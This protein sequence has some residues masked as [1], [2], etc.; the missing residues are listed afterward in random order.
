MCANR[1][2]GFEVGV[3]VGF[4]QRHRMN[5]MSD[6]PIASHSF[7]VVAGCTGHATTSRWVDVTSGDRH[8]VVVCWKHEGGELSLQDLDADKIDWLGES[9]A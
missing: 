5:P 2:L 3:A 6:E 9:S 1:W 4:E 8:Q 7:C